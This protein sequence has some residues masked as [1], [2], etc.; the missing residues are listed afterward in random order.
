ME[1][2]LHVGNYTHPTTAGRAKKSF[3]GEYTYI[4]R[5]YTKGSF[6]VESTYVCN[7]AAGTV[8]VS[9]RSKITFQ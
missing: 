7:P 4:I 3:Y 1:G 8:A 9:G 5:A 6:V 2:Y